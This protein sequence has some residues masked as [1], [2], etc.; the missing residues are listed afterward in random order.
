MTKGKMPDRVL[1]T[2]FGSFG[3]FIPN[4]STEVARILGDNSAQPPHVIEVSFAAVDSFVDQLDPTTF[5]RWLMLGATAHSDRMRVERVARNRVGAL[6]DVRGIVRGPAEIDAGSG[7]ALP[8]TLWD[9]VHPSDSDGWAWSDDAGDYL[10][11]YLYWRAL[12][13]FPQKRIGF[14]HVPPAERMPITK[15][16]EVA[17]ELLRRVRVE[18]LT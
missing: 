11:N 12:R 15:Q 10:C 5:D 16:L 3:Q 9:S 17:R 6:P 18:S 13:R 8:G 2:G 4:P 14:V 1:V 7:E